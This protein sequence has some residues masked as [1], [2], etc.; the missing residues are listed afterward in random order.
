MGEDLRL[1]EKLVRKDG[2]FLLQTSG[3]VMERKNWN[4]SPF[5]RIS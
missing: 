1:D 4:K 3:L 2:G 5:I